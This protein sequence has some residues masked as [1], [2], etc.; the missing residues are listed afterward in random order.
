LLLYIHDNP[1][2]NRVWYD[3]VAVGTTY[4]GPLQE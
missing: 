3:D 4:I 1:Q 2:V